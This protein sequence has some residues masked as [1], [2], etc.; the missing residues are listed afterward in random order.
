MSGQEAIAIDKSKLEEVRHFFNET[1]LGWMIGDLRRSVEANTNFLTALGCL[2]YT[3]AVG[4][5]LPRLHEEPKSSLEQKRFYRCLFRLKSEEGLR[6]LDE[7]T[8]RET[9]KGIYQ[10]LRHSGAHS[11]FFSIAKHTKD[12]K[13]FYPVGVSRDGK[14]ADGTKSSPL[15]FATDDGSL[16]IA[17]ANY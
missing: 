12:G 1:I 8:K 4:V 3:E 16:I 15:G 5:F 10:Q 7:S 9:G 13:F 14:L 6:K 17:T 11:Y 2:T